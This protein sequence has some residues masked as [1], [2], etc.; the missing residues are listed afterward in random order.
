MPLQSTP[1]HVAVAVPD[2][3]A[4]TPRWRDELGGSL[5]SWSHRHGRFRGRQYRYRNEARVELLAP[6]EHANPE[7]NFV[8]RFLDS[9]GSAVHHFTLKVPDVA[10]AA[11]Q[12]DAAGLDVVDL[13]TSDEHW[14]E[15][16]LRPSQVGGI[17]V[18]I[19]WTP[20]SQA[21]FAAYL[22]HEIEPPPRDGAE[23]Q[24]PLLRHPD[25]EVAARLW[26]LLGA[27]VGRDAGGLMCTWLGEPLT[28]RV[29]PASPA[30]PL[31]LRFAG[32]SA[33]PPDDKLGTAVIPAS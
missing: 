22:D 24:G 8:R 33:L 12:L 17:V 20:W 27:E 21:E 7:T 15:A 25:L 23:L 32:A 5:T 2:L 26:R 19:A 1:D 29:V 13:D 18:Q 30:G 11:E 10:S 14:H 3:D 28:V 16:F 9:H 6:D 4:A 31:G